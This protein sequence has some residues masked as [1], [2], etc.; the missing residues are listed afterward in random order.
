MRK[1][2]GF[3][4]DSESDLPVAARVTEKRLV[5]AQPKILSKVI[6][7]FESKLGAG[8]PDLR[9]MTTANSLQYRACQQG[10]EGGFASD[11]QFLLRSSK[12]LDRSV[13]GLFALGVC[14]SAR[15]FTWGICQPETKFE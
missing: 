5:R 13:K 3:V 1:S 10:Q 14:R 8:R 2:D 6:T 12:R 11:S 4:P 15:I 9:W 7:R